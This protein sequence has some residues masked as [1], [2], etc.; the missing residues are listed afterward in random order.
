MGSRLPASG[1]RLSPPRAI[2]WEF[3]WRHR[4]GFLA[5]GVY[6][7]VLAAIKLVIVVRNV[8]VAFDSEE[9]FALAVVVPITVSFVYLL[10]V[11]TYGLSGDLAARQ[12]MYPARMFTLPLSNAALVDWPMLYG[13]TALVGLWIL[14]RWLSV[15]PT[16]FSIPYVWPATLAAALVMWTQALVWMPYGLAGMRVIVS[17]VVLWVIDAIVLLA[18]HFKAAEWVIVAI[19]APQI[20]VAY[21]IGRVAVARARRGVVP[22]WRLPSLASL[23][24]RVAPARGEQ[25]EQVEHSSAGRAQSWYE[26]RCSGKSLAV[27]VAIILPLELVLLWAAGTSTTLVIVIVLGAL[28]TPVIVAAFAGVSASSMGGSGSARDG[29]GLSPFIAA[30]PLTDAQLLS[31]KLRMT[32]RSTLFA[33]VIVLLAIPLALYS[34]GT[35]QTLRD[36]SRNVAAIIGVPRTVVLLGVVV[37]GMMLS[38]WRQLVQSLHFGLSGNPRLIKGSVFVSLVLASLLGPLAIWIV[39]TDR[40]GVVWS[41]MPVILALLVLAKMLAAGL[42]AARLVRERP[43]GDRA[44]IAGALCWTSAVVAL[45][46]LLAWLADT[47]HIPRYLV[48]L[49]AILSVPLARLSAA[50]LAL[51]RNRHR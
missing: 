10:A 2:A 5:V 32:I 44:L 14:T 24:S 3:T 16:E 35:W 11:F 23:L 20:P 33:W 38:T 50:P 37:A 21:A 29:Y 8:P 1:S 48:M 27:W 43:L 36:W 40:V 51:A 17:V 6:L 7:A 12:S 49:L 47:P 28:V 19:T 30:R 34:S 25:I 42:V 45:F 15:W 9:S 26:W 41:V 13:T 4:W 31:A 46:A 39:D 18:L 22:Q